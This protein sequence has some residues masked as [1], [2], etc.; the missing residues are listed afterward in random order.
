MSKTH[1][2]PTFRAITV[3]LAIAIVLSFSPLLTLSARAVNTEALLKDTIANGTET[4]I[5]LTG[6][7]NI[8]DPGERKNGLDI[9]RTVT[10][11]LN[12]KT[13]E[14][15]TSSEDTNGIK[16]AAGIMLTIKDSVGS[17]QL[18]VQNT[19]GLVT[20]TG[21]NAGINTTDAALTVLGGT[22][23]ATGGEGAAGIGGGYGNDNGTVI[24]IGGTITANGRK[25][26]AGIGGGGI[27]NG[28][29]VTI[30]GGNIIA[31][32]GKY[33][34]GI[35]GG[36]HGNGG[37]VTISGG[38]VTAI[39]GDNYDTIGGSYY[40]RVIGGTG[41]GGGGVYTTDPPKA[42]GTLT[43]TGGSVRTKFGT[44]AISDSDA[45]RIATDGTNP[46]LRVN[47]ESYYTNNAMP[48]G[49][50]ISV[51]SYKAMTD[52]TGNAYIWIPNPVGTEVTFAKDGYKTATSQVFQ[53]IG[54]GYFAWT[55]MELFTNAPPIRKPGV[56]ATAT[57]SVKV[58]TA[59]TLDLSTIFEDADA[60]DVLTYYVNVDGG[61]A[62]STAQNYSFTPTA[63]GTKTLIFK[64]N[65][66]TANSTDT[67]TVALTATVEAATP[68]VFPFTD[69]PPGIWYRMDVEIAH[70]NGL[71]NGTTATT[72]SPIN[73][74]TVAE[75]VK[76]AVCMHQLYHNGAVTLQNGTPVWYSTFMTYAL[77]NGIIEAD[78]T[79]RA[80]EKLT[81]Q[82]F[83]YIFYAALPE[84]QY[85]AINT[86]ADNAIPD[87]PLTTTSKYA[88]RIY[89]FYRAGILTGS[90]TNGTFN[91]TSN[92]RRQEVAAI[93]TRMFD[94]TARKPIT[95]S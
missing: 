38:S 51:G 92:I 77:T 16:I 89:T 9:T 40:D 29:N 26:G 95:L 44:R 69:V 94:A 19:R 85:V 45:T 88:Q 80:N 42:P 60:S 7:I 62:G 63:A 53:L 13:L 12:G 23:T 18:I 93:L 43:I 59:Y 52:A 8:G 73:N 79:G 68:Y 34:A 65:D 33:A 76:L 50:E 25:G 6:N 48:A 36:I 21:Y 30:S 31:T 81:R 86:V 87:V 54:R 10:L 70:K 11:D 78:L 28:G 72:F 75:A 1:T 90:D 47:I 15:T 61:A 49:V 66:G 22:V 37:T 84:S 74:M 71:V 82:E 20:N 56:P 17:G 2:K 83:V 64:A 57:A 46:V 41:I 91:P 39:G 67:Y 5:K 27:S 55:E 3:F 24:I 4:E 58:N 35:G 32:G 14:I